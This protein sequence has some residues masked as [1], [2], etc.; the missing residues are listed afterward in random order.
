ML[1]FEP[2]LIPRLVLGRWSRVCYLVQGSNGRGSMLFDELLS[3][4]RCFIVGERWESL[5]GAWLVSE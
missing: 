5:S 2:Y 1:S 4:L 3:V